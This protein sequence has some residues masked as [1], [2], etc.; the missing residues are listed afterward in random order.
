MV[1]LL[2]AS[3]IETDVTVTVSHPPIRIGKFYVPLM[4][5]AARSA[6]KK[7]YV[8]LMKTAARSA[9]KKLRIIIVPRCAGLSIHCCVV[10][11]AAGDF[12]FSP[13]V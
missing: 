2:R 7:I 5:T 9:A 13:F 4:K 11:S 12:F 6:A 10:H 3:A 1:T 8:P